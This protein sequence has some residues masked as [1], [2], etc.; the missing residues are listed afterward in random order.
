MS[1]LEV[2]THI[3]R[4]GLSP[5]HQKKKKTKTKTKQPESVSALEAGCEA[6]PTCGVASAGSLSALTPGHSGL[7]L[8][9]SQGFCHHSLETEPAN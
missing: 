6:E 1:A 8:W 3:L 7:S 5:H 2:V 9:A 4:A